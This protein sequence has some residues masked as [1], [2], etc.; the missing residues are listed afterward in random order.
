MV[1]WWLRPFKAK[2]IKGKV[3][4]KLLK[5]PHDLKLSIHLI[6]DFNWTNLIKVRYVTDLL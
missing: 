2:G 3:E 4:I 1:I 6:V 5:S